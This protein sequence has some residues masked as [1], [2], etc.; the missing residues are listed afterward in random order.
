MW[1]D[2][3]TGQYEGML[4]ETVC[5]PGHG[6]KMIRSYV[7]RP[8]GVT[9]CP[10]LVLIP[11]MPG[12][13]EWCRECARRFSQH[14]YAVACPNI[15]QDFDP[16]GTPEEASKAAIAQGGARDGDVMADVAGSLAYL[17]GQSWSNGKVGVIGMCSGGRHAFLAACT[18]EGFDA[19]VDCWGGGVVMKE[20]D[21]SPARPVAPID[22]TGQLSCP[23]IGIFGN[24]D[25]MPTPQEVDIHEE[26]L[27]KA[28]K[29]YEFHRYDGAGH[30]IW[31][32]HKP[33]YRREQAMDSQ[34]KVY[35]FLEKHLRT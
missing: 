16:D 3:K 11:H 1:N 27:K 20:E 22:Y 28:G 31:Y 35:A 2:I 26:A 4:A 12:W 30:G 24:D 8:L 33:M 6:G 15:Y 34:E 5:Y 21:L 7:S 29:E 18:V 10:S 23:L 13:D 9:D 25:K 19:A 17:K 14:G 32:Y